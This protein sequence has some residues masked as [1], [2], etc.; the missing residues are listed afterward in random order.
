MGLLSQGS[1]L[2]W[3]NTKK[4]ADYI[5]SHG[6]I[7]FVNIY[8]NLKDRQKDVLKWG[9]EV[10]YFPLYFILRTCY[11]CVQCLGVYFPD[12]LTV[13][14]SMCSAVMNLRRRLTCSASVCDLNT[15][16]CEQNYQN[17]E[18]DYPVFH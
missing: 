15:K 14:C 11:C 16:S 3:E 5:R 9:D 13:M 4:Y 7:Q 18:T 6:I 1:P 8:N 2:N 12:A 10:N 17:S